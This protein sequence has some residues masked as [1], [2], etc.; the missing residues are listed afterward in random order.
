MPGLGLCE[1]C[2]YA[3]PGARET[4]EGPQYGSVQVIS[5]PFTFPMQCPQK[6]SGIS[7]GRRGGCKERAFQAEGV[8]GIKAWW[9]QVAWGGGTPGWKCIGRGDNS[10]RG[11]INLKPVISTALA[12]GSLAI[13]N[14]GKLR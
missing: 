4:R 12:G 14:L 2:E 3:D 6:Q 8:A 9:L 5:N 7:T 13:S 10:R 11:S 1:H